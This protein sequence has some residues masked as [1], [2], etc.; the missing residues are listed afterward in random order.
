MYAICHEGLVVIAH[1]PCDVLLVSHLA[2]MES[3]LLLVVAT[4]LKLFRSI[5]TLKKNSKDLILVTNLNNNKNIKKNKFI[6]F[7]FN[8]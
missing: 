1:S 3:F 4:T 7:E 6:I 2:D 8:K 5:T